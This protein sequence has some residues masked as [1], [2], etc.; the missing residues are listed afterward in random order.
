MY[1]VSLRY[2]LISIVLVRSLTVFS[3]KC[4]IV[5][6]EIDLF[7][8]GSIPSALSHPRSIKGEEEVGRT[9]ACNPAHRA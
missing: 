7:G 6:T 9:V 5:E 3:R 2:P 1:R 4:A 8:M